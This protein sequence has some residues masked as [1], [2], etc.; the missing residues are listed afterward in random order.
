MTVLSNITR[1]TPDFA[2]A[3]AFEREDFGALAEA[4]FKSVINNRPDW[5]DGVQLVS[6]QARQA[7]YSV[8]LGYCYLPA[9]SQSLFDTEF[10][11]AFED[12]LAALPGPVVAHCKTGTRTAILWA[13]V[14]I[15]RQ[16]VDAVLAQ[17]EAAGHDLW[18]LQTELEAYAEARAAEMGVD[19]IQLMPAF[20]PA[21][22]DAPVAAT[23]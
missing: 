2:L 4:G 9:D 21:S 13:Q 16:P 20:E 17:L 11:R 12:S 15:R 23:L 14:M 6:D 18:F 10:V 3:P 7:A 8:G 1:I 19:A 5:E 22:A